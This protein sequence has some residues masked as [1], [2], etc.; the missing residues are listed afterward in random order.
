M[1]NELKPCP[2]CGDKVELIDHTDRTFGFDGHEIKCHQCK[3]IMLSIPANSIGWFKDGT[4][5]V[6]WTKEKSLNELK[7]RWNRRADNDR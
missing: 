7:E 5:I 2:F 3:V 4:P 6:E 1:P